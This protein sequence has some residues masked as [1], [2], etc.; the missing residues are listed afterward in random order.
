[1][2]VVECAMSARRAPQAVVADLHVVAD[3]GDIAAAFV[4]R[5][6][7]EAGSAPSCDR[8]VPP[9]ARR[10]LLLNA[11]GA[12]D[13]GTAVHET[14]SILRAFAGSHRD[15]VVEIVAVVQ[16]GG[17]FGLAT[18]P[19]IHAEMGG[20]A[21]LVKTAAREWPH[22]RVRIVDVPR[23]ISASTIAA[24]LWDALSLDSDD[25]EI[26]VAS[27]GTMVR[28]Q[29][30][31][32][33]KRAPTRP[34]DKTETWVVSGGARGVTAACLAALVRRVPV[35]LALFG[36]TPIDDV[37]SVEIRGCRTNAELKRA[38]FDA[39]RVRGE[40]VSPLELQRAAERILSSREA[41]ENCDALR[42]AGADVTYVAI[43]IADRDAVQAAVAE[44]RRTLGPIRG[45]VHAAGVLADKALHDKSD[46]QF[47]SVY[48]TKV[49]GFAALLEATREDALTTLCCFSS[50]AARVGNAGQADYAA[51]N[52]ALNKLCQAEQHRR[53]ET[54]LV[55][56]IGW[57][58]WDGGMVSP[59]LRAHFASRGVP[60]ISLTDGADVFA[61]LMTG[62]LATTVECIV[63]APFETPL[64]P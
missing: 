55:R 58:P 61:D 11:L 37:E 34:I 19:G 49:Q 59:A 5:C 29:L 13:A 42:A 45:V 39:S 31:A 43:D 51:A 14:F 25:I 22:A 21:G 15:H 40:T 2:H 12:K 20:I 44:V 23:D 27:D 63:G 26:G 54:C 52:E 30:D 32:V 56:S 18:D 4:Q 53:G 47:Q 3:R 33:T 57:G 28:P 35:R 38:L 60:L 50:V 62:A 16:L 9:S 36:R 17:D 10:L 46:A 6:V 1:V 8:E 24:R 41:R 64:S 48:R 7:A